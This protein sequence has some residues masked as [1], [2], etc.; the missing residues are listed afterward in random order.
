[1][2]MN[3][4]IIIIF[5][6]TAAAMAGTPGYLPAAGPTTLRFQKPVVAKPMA[7]LPASFAIA[8][9]PTEK[10][11][12]PAE[13]AVVDLSV[14]SAPEPPS[15]TLMQDAPVTLPDTLAGAQTNQVQTLIGPIMDTSGLVT[16]QM[17][18]RFFTSPQGGVS[19]EAIVVTPPGFTPAHPPTT[20]PSSVIYTQ[21]EP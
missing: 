16:P 4:V 20:T 21:P 7:K 15:T 13:N 9:A 3:G 2:R 1:M 18:L 12:P 17:F 11:A 14:E 5:G 6:I 10:V 19:Q 8:P